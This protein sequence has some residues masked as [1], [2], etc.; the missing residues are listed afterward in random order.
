MEFL[1]ADLLTNAFRQAQLRL[2]VY[3]LIS[4]LIKIASSQHVPF[5][6]VSSYVA[7]LVLAT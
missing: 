5:R 3:S 1:L 7:M 2:I 4:S 6:Q